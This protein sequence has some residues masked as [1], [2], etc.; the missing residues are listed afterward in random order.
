M[1]IN[2]ICTDFSTSTCVLERFHY[3]GNLKA[4]LSKPIKKVK[5]NNTALIEK[6][7]LEKIF[8][9]FYSN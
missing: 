8:L 7:V 3:F 2:I 9:P 1:C 4:D 6:L 5:I